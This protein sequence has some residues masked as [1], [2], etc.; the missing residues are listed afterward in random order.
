MKTYLQ[1][2]IYFDITF[3]TKAMAYLV[4]RE[5]NC[6]FKEDRSYMHAYFNILL[7]S[8]DMNQVE[9]QVSSGSAIWLLI[10]QS[11]K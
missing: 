11:T 9:K 8:H 10:N 7:S 2:H 6:F 5:Y 3:W 4:I 1:L